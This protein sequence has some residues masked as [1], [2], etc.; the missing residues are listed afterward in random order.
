MWPRPG[1][2]V[3]SLVSLGLPEDRN[4]EL[5]VL[6]PDSRLEASALTDEKPEAT[7]IKTLGRK[8]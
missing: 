7:S 1:Y 4:T 6:R 2:D 5:P 3:T 8:G